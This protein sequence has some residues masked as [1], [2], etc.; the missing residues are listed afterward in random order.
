MIKEKGL[1]SRKSA[2]AYIEFLK[3]NRI[4]FEVSIS[5][6]TVRVK[7]KYNQATYL[8]SFRSKQCFAAFAKIKSDVR[9]REVP[10]IRKSELRYYEHNFISSCNFPAITNIDLKSAYASVL[11]N[12]GYITKQ[13]YDY[14]AKLSKMDRLASV[15]MLAGRKHIVKYDKSG[16][17]YS[18]DFKVAETE[19]FFF[20]CVKK[21][22]E[23]MNTIRYLS[24]DKFLFS[25]VDGVYILEDPETEK[26]I[27]EYLKS[28]GY[29]FSIDRLTD[30]DV[31]YLQSKITI[32]FKKGGELKEFNIPARKG[33]FANDLLYYL[34]NIKTENNVF[35]RNPKN[36]LQAVG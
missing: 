31:K 10:K 13:T 20:Y 17:A 26:T 9:K 25:W 33:Y 15:G 29:N 19:N 23:I 24:G 28:I 7:S 32:T 18:H 6:Y 14:C 4:P 2:R 12:D 34:T 35:R 21:V 30:F 1:F 27:A 8:A 22:H 11:M 5:N 36:S 3:H 16:R